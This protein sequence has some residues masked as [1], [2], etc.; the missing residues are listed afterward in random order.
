MVL[1]LIANVRD[2]RGYVRRTYGER[3]VAL[4]P[5]ELR[6]APVFILDPFRGIAFQLANQCGNIERFR[7]AAEY[8]SVVLGATNAKRR[9]A[10]MFANT[11]QICVQAR[12]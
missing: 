3:A 10:L 9:R 7:E 11:S 4:L 2:G 5:I 1:F 6:K 12:S 8:V